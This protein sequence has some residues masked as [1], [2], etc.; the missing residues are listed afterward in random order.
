MKWLYSSFFLVLFGASIC[1][2]LPENIYIVSADIKA[3]A[4]LPNPF[5]L[6]PNPLL[7][8]SW[9]QKLLNAVTFRAFSDRYIDQELAG[10]VGQF[11]EMRAKGYNVTIINKTEG[12]ELLRI[13]GDDSTLAV[14]HVGHSYMVEEPTGPIESPT[15]EPWLSI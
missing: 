3:S 14:F 11:D 8:L 13:L 6:N 12:E 4:Y 2:A 15:T 5:D 7:P 1:N 9:Y 10:V